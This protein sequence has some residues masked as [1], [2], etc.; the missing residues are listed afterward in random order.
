MRGLGLKDG[1]IAAVKA[2][3]WSLTAFEIGLFGWMVLMRFVFFGRHLHPNSPV[4]W[5]MMHDRHDHRLRDHLPD[6]LVPRPRRYQGRYV[7]ASP[8]PVGH[9]TQ[10][11]V[12]KD[13]H[14]WLA[15]SRC[16]ANTA[17]WRVP[18][19][20]QIGKQFREMLVR[21]CVVQRFPGSISKAGGHDVEVA[22]GESRERG[23]FGK[24]WRSRPLVLAPPC[25]GA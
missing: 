22:L 14:F 6:E 17:G 18:L 4:Y 13:F 16:V 12:R 10:F 24:Y 25:Q 2:D 15:D 21:R 5:F 7:S 9:F 20:W 11:E 8:S 19:A 3:F 1:I 23:A